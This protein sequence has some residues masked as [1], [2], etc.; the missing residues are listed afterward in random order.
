MEEEIER[1]VRR[2]LKLIKRVLLY[3]NYDHNLSDW[4]IRSS[5]NDQDPS[6]LIGMI[7]PFGNIIDAPVNVVPGGVSPCFMI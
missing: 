3:D 4:F 5:R 1:M 6:L 7:S 2:N